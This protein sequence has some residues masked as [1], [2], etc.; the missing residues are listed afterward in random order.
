MCTQIPTW[1]RLSLTPTIASFVVQR[2]ST[3]YCYYYSS[4]RFGSAVKQLLQYGRQLVTGFESI[5]SHFDNEIIKPHFWALIATYSIK[6]MELNHNK[7][8]KILW[9]NEKW[10]DGSIWYWVLLVLSDAEAI[11]LS[12][13]SLKCLNRTQFISFLSEFCSHKLA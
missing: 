10:D 12:I 7:Y 13:K 11:F 4:D 1:N 9:L 3:C 6:L 8:G 2:S 5:F